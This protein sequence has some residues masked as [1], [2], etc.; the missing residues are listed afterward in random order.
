MLK[1]TV[2]LFTGVLLSLTLA[3]CAFARDKVKISNF[4]GTDKLLAEALRKHDKYFANATITSAT[5]DAAGRVT[6]NFTVKDRGGKGVGGIK[7]VSFSV[8]KLI[9]AGKGES[10]KKWV[11]YVWR[12]EVVRGSAA[13]QWP[14]PDGTA[15]DQGDRETKGTLTDN[16]NGSYRYVFATNLSKIRTPVAGAAVPYERNRLPRVTLMIGG[17]DGPTATAYFDFVPDG[18]SATESRT[19]VQTD[20]CKAC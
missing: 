14:N 19:I 3:V 10:F 15:A 5:A 6:V 13:G 12:S 9:P 7:G 1:L 20:A 11:P 4:H 16:K 2:Y 18:S 8:A 17:H